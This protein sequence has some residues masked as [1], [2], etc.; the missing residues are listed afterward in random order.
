M[1]NRWILAG[2]V[3]AGV[4]AGG[5]RNGLG[6]D[7]PQWRGANRDAIAAEFKAPKTWPKELTQKWK[8]TVGEGVATPS[9][10]GDKLYVFSRENGNEIIR[11]LNVADGRELWQDKYD[12]L[13][14]S[15]SNRCSGRCRSG[16]NCHSARTT[17][18]CLS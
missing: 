10:V 15:N 18:G 4:V 2:M 17:R 13:G 8:V 14:G 12:S 5:T 16:L 6:Q 7:W 9:L 3:A 1:M 11:C